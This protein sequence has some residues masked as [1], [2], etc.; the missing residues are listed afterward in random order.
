ME[1]YLIGSTQFGLSRDEDQA[2]PSGDSEIVILPDSTALTQSAAISS[3]G[4]ATRGSRRNLD[5]KNLW[6]ESAGMHSHSGYRP[7]RTC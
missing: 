6:S 3:N 1:N 7:S 2:L 5:P 4:L